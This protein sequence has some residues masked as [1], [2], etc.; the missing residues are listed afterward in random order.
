LLDQIVDCV[1]YLVDLRQ[2]GY[3]LEE[4]SMS[5]P[6][7]DQRI[8]S[9]R[10]FNRFYTQKI[11]VLDEGLL[12]SS[13]SLTEARVLYEL[14]HRE[15]PTA[16]EIARDLD[17][18]PGYLSR[19]LRG[20]R[21]RGLIDRAPAAADRRRRHLSLTAAGRAAFAPLDVRSRQEI[22]AL[23]GTLPG[24]AQARLVGAM[25]TIERLLDHAAAPAEAVALRPYRPGDMGWIVS[26]HGALYA[27]EYGW[28]QEFEAM[29][30]EIAAGF[31]GNFDPRRERCWIAEQNGEPVG[32]VALAAETDSAAR[33]RLLLVEPQGRGLGLGRRLVAESLGFARQA[34][35]RKVVLSTFNV[36]VAARRIYETAGFRLRTEEP[37]DRFG[38]RLVEEIWQLDL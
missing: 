22:G 12:H 38:H 6:A 37:Q 10:R 31:L 17:L 24:T 15:R 23:I 14:A 11:G 8:A 35:Y 9:V 4:G 21:R 33:L 30:A 2:P 32:S 1:N 28:N 29:V 7:I 26:R 19:M 27:E 16:G 13:F 36:L 18:D 20:F 34:G 25:Q 3:C 5:A